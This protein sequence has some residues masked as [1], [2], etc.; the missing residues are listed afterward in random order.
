MAFTQLG[1]TGP[2]LD[3]STFQLVK[4]ENINEK[5]W[6]AMWLSEL[7]IDGEEP[8]SLT[9]DPL[10]C[11]IAKSI[12]LD[13]FEN[14]GLQEFTTGIWWRSRC[15]F[16][17]QKLF[18]NHSATL[19]DVMIDGIQQMKKMIPCQV[20]E[21]REL[22]CRILLEHGLML[23]YYGND[24]QAMQL[25]K[26]AQ[27][28]SQLQWD[29]TGV[30][31]KRTKFQQFETSQ[32]VIMASSALQV[33]ATSNA[34]QQLQH[35]DETLLENVEFTEKSTKE[36]QDKMKGNLNPIDQSLLLAFCLNVKNTN[37]VDGLTTEEMFPYV[38]V[39]IG[40]IIEY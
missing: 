36:D 27:D 4:P 38:T 1:W 7:V 19:H 16:T 31:G 10:L 8:Y 24:V 14:R 21:D 11:W 39:C 6:H 13:M 33:S 34:P 23:H 32:L 40:I 12:F 17:L 5:E 20:E 30:L 29:V 2:N 9:P 3:F 37:P 15:A 18:D 26:Q 25:F 28:A 35:N 22:H